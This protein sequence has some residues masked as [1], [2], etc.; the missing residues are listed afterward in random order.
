[1]RSLVVL[2]LVACAG[3]SP[4]DTAAD[5]TTPSSDGTTPSTTETTEPTSVSPEATSSSS[6]ASGETGG[7]GGLS[8]IGFIV[9]GV[10]AVLAIGGAITGGL[11]M[12]QES[13]LATV[14]PGDVCP[15]GVDYESMVSNGQT[16]ALVTDILIPVGIAALAAGVV[17]I[18]VLEGDGGT[19]TAAG[20]FCGPD[21][22]M[23]ALRTSF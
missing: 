18:L 11:A 3:K 23:G 16:L 17:L 15:A 2:L 8:P 22:C 6:G 7:G 4:Q 20:A 13:S 5:S 10:G 19:E 1:M 14:C 12:D 9:G 21:G